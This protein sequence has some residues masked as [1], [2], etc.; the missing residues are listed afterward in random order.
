MPSG[1]A[2]ANITAAERWFIREGRPVV[3][4]VLNR[5]GAEVDVTGFTIA[6]R[7]SK[8]RGG[9]S[10]LVKSGAAI[11]KSVPPGGSLTSRV[12]V[13]TDKADFT[14]FSAGRHYHA[15]VRT[16]DTVDEPVLAE[17]YVDRLPG[18]SS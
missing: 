9:S 15:L 4:D 3:F 12:T 10:P 5:A 7:Y 2:V 6:Y 1:A 14:G 8:N 18:P 11:T 16:D 13:N 17:G